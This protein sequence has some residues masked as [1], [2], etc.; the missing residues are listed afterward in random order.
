MKFKG[1]YQ[2]IEDKNYIKDT[3]KSLALKNIINSRLNH[4][5]LRNCLLR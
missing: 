2:G 5:E 4:T 1:Q 3:D